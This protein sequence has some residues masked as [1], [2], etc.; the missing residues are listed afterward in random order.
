MNLDGR[1]DGQDVQIF[2]DVLLGNN[3][4]P[5]LIAQADFDENTLLNSND[6]ALFVTALLSGVT[7]T[8]TVTLFAQ[9]LSASA[10]LCDTPVD[11]LTD[12]N[13]NGTFVL[14]G[15]VE[16]TVVL[17]TLS[18][19]S[20]PAGTRVTASMSPAT[21]P[22]TFTANTTATWVGVFQPLV[23][24]PSASFQIQYS[25]AQVREQSVAQ[26]DL[27]VGDGT[28]VNAPD[29]ATTRAPGSLVGTLSLNFGNII[30][31]KPFSFAPT[32]TGQW[33]KIEYMDSSIST[34]PP[35]LGV[36]PDT[37]EVMALSIEDNPEDQHESVFV[38][39]YGFHYAALVEIE[40]NAT[41]VVNSPASLFVDLVSYDSTAAQ[42]H[43]LSNIELVKVTND[44]DPSLII[45]TS[46]L[47]KPVIL[48][49]YPLDPLDFPNVWLLRMPEGGEGLAAIVSHFGS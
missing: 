27:I 48:V 43:V 46:D 15:T 45:Y 18:P 21:A 7:A 23:G 19:S 8:S 6:T 9:G 31:A 1:V 14:A 11:I 26:A 25:A 35:V 13:E 2:V 39:A 28:L 33:R 20:G 22:L 24:S 4:N 34:G 37:L 10:S 17:L 44:G 12:E 49:D 29:F 42:F 3:T 30:V 5:A 16:T 32:P 47:E 38:H 41:T 36:E 40:E